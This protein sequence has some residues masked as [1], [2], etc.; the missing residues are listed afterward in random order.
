MKGRQGKE[1]E[2]KDQEKCF[3][4]YH[5]RTVDHSI[6]ECQEFVRLVQEMMNEGEI[7]FYGKM[8]EPNVSFLL[9]EA[10]KLVTI[11]YRVGGQQAM[12]KVPHLPTPRLVVKVPAPFRYTSDKALPWN[13]TS[14]AVIQEPQAGTEQKL[15]TSVNDIAGMGRMNRSGRCY[16]PV[17]SGARKGKNS[18]ESGGVK[19]AVSKKK[20]QRADE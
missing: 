10:P 17:N 2:I 13:Y 18:V 3:C 9:E 19:I 4:Q 1:E 12:K 16:A 14:Q 15:E 5:R 8:E 7:E 20:R 11:F 6:Q